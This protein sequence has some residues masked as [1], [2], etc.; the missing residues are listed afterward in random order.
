MNKE[1]KT[2]TLDEYNKIGELLKIEKD[3][4]AKQGNIVREAKQKKMSKEELAPLIEKLKQLQKTVSELTA[5]WREADPN[6]LHID[7]KEF[8]SLL[9]RRFF[10]VPAFEIYGGNEHNC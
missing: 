2:T 8:E 7:K 10:V 3:N 4:L 6:K 9:T 1:N 5:K